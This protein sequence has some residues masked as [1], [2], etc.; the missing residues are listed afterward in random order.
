MAGLAPAL[1]L[2]KD[3]NDGY[4]LIKSLGGLA[5]QNLKMLILTSPGERMMNPDFGVGLRNY[6]FR[7]NSPMVYGDIE[8]KIRSQ[9]S[10]YLPYIRILAV[11]FKKSEE[12]ASVEHSISINIEYFVVPLRVKG[13]LIL[14][15]EFTLDEVI[16]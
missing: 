12:Y 14:D 4:R 1:P 7:Q 13:N 11:N 16:L 2:R 6:H 8:T 10:R 9:V 15:T 5:L 3:E